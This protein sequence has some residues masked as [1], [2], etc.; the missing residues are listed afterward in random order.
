MDYVNL[1]ILFGLLVVGSALR[2]F[3]WCFAWIVS[4]RYTRVLGEAA[5]AANPAEMRLKVS[6]LLAYLDKW[7]LKCFRVERWPNG[8]G[9]PNR[10]ELGFVASN[11][12][13]LDKGRPGWI[14]APVDEE[15]QL[16]ELRSL[17]QAALQ[18]DYQPWFFKKLP[19]YLWVF[20][21]GVVL[22]WLSLI[23]PVLWFLVACQGADRRN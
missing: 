11:L 8:G 2:G 7:R 12:E 18:V 1:K 23:Y 13:D 6:E 15:R 14:G 10:A 22:T 3:H 19:T 4:T 9:S 20:W 5:A 16:S 21:V 17:L